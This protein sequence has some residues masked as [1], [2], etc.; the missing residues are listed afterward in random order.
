M[1]MKKILQALDGVSASSQ[2]SAEG[3]TDMAKFISII[4]KNDV[5]VLTEGANPHKVTL[6]VQMAM[7]HYQ[8][9]ETP[10]K[11]S[12][13]KKYFKE[14]EEELSAQN[15]KRKALLTQYAQKISKTVLERGKA[16]EGLDINLLK[17]AQ[18]HAKEN[19]AKKDPESERNAHKKYG[20][21]TDSGPEDRGLD[22]LEHPAD[23]KKKKKVKEDAGMAQS[24]IA[25]LSALKGQFKEPW[26][27][28]QLDYR[29]K[30]VQSGMVPR[31]GSGGEIKVLDPVAW[32]RSTDPT[33]IARIVGKDG[34][35]PE[36]LEKSNML[37]RGLDYI[38]LPGQHPTN[39]GLKFE[40][41]K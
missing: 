30:A 7:Q 22:D 32:E 20:Y 14:A 34:L 18:K 38:G 23:K 19:P 21:R 26:M 33:T 40:S 29:I 1:D 17:A 35:S 5:K 39:P 8:K 4:E 37:G 11:E 3:K 16:L 9:E 13:L 36:Y 12:V 24:Y 15:A 2:K 41:G 31:S 10:K 25:Q 27:Q 28:K 6:P